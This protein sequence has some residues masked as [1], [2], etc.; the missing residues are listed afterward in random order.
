MTASSMFFPPDCT[1]SSSAL[2]ASLMAS[3][4]PVMASSV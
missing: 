4:S 2:M 3:L 1:T